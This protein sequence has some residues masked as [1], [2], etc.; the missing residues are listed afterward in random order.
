MAINFI[1]YNTLLTKLK[2]MKMFSFVPLTSV[3]N[4]L[5]IARRG[6]GK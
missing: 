2:I 6:D 1:Y 5:C 4:V 3:T